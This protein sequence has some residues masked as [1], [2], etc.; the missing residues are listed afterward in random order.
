MKRGDFIW[1]F[2]L[3]AIAF[4][5]IFPA[6]NK[7]YMNATQV[8]PYLMGFVKFA[9]LATM[10]EFLTTRILKRRWEKPD[11]MIAKAVV[12]GIIGVLSVLMFQLFP[13]GV[14]SVV[15]SGYLPDFSGWSGSLFIAFTASAVINLSF[16]PIFMAFHR[17]TDAFIDAR[18]RGEKNKVTAIIEKIDWAGFIKF[19]VCKTIPYFWIP[20]HTITFLLPGEYRI[21]TAAFL[22]IAL[23]AILAYAKRKK[24]NRA[25]AK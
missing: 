9:V 17:I 20:A 5:L 3:L 13:A 14:A 10:G 21:L 12:W 8:S 16:A 1:G 24:E 6:T 23:G 2:L 25:V 22:S 18:C 15:K 11:G 7:I 19:V 4:F